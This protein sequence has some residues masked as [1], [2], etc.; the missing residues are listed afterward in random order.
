[1][2]SHALESYDALSRPHPPTSPIATPTLSEALRSLGLRRTA[3]DLADFLAGTRSR[4]SPAVCLEELSGPRPRT[5][6]A[7]VWSAG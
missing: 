6:P 7:G 4:W 5:A 1:V 3:A 2:S